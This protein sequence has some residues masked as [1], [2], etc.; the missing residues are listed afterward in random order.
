VRRWA[1]KV[2]L[3]RGELV[4]R[5]GRTPTEEE[6]ARKLGVEIAEHR[7]FL[8]RYRRAQVDSLEAR[9]EYDGNLGG[10]LHGIVA[11]SRAVDLEPAAEK[12]EVRA[13]FVEAIKTLGEHERVVP[14][15]YSHEGLTLREIGGALNLTES[16]ISQILHPALAK[17]NEK[18]SEDLELSGRRLGRGRISG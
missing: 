16:R 13:R 8:D 1:R 18:L 17:L 4:Q 9:L 10:E 2:E 15:L 11:D 7:A 14:T 5:L 12:A 3:A 6:V